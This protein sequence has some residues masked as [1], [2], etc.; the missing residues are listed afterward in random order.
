M[1]SERDYN[2]EISDTADHQ[3]AYGFDLD[4][5]HPLMLRSFSP[6]FRDGSCLELM[7]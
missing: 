5:I 6:H 3:Y 2:A 1:R 7:F 4:V